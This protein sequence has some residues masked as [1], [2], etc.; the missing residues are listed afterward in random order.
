MARAGHTGRKQR[1]GSHRATGLTEAGENAVTGNPSELHR[2][3]RILDASGC[4]SATRLISS[5]LASE[6]SLGV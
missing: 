3:R 2:N 6:D 4:V 1:P 5:S